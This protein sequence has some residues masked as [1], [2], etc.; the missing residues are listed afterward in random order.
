LKRLLFDLETDG[1]WEEVSHVH[2]IVTLDLDTGESQSFY[3]DRTVVHP[4]RSGSLFDGVQELR[5]A[6]ELWGHNIL[7]YDIPVLNKILKAGFN[8][9]FDSIKIRD[10]LVCSQHM[11][12]ELK[13]KDFAFRKTKPDFPGT[14]VGSHSLEA[15]GWRLDNHKD[16]FGKDADWKKFTLE[17]LTYALQD[18]ST[19]KSLIDLIVSKNYSEAALENE[20]RFQWVIWLQEQHGFRF[21]RKA[22]VSLYGELSQRRADIE[23]QLQAGFPGWYEEMKTPEYY[24]LET[25][26]QCDPLY[27]LPTKAD[28]ERKRRELGIKPSLCT[29]KPGPLKKKHTPF[30]PGSR[31]HIAKFLIEKYGWEPSQFGDDGKPT[32]DEDVLLE[33]KYPEIP[34]IS[35]YLMVEKRIGQLAEGNK[36][37]LKLE[38]NGRIHGRVN[39]NGAV[40]TRV[41]HNEPNMSQVPAVDKPFGKESRALFV[42]DEGHVL[43]GADASGIQLR[44]L[45]HYMFPWDNGEYGKIVLNGSSKLGT[46]IHTM[47]QKAAGLATRDMAKTFIYAFLLGAQ[48]GK[49]ASIAQTTRA[50]GQ[51][52][53]EN[54]LAKFPALAAL[55]SEVSQRVKSVGYLIGPDGRKLPTRSDHAAL[56]SLLQGFESAVMK[57]ATWITHEKLI[58]LG[59]VHGKD[60]AQVGYFHDELQITCR[61]D[62]GDT[63]GKTV[64]A[65]IEQAGR[66]FDSKCPLTGEYRVGAN[67]RDT[68]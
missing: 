7:K 1:L 6:S 16:T 46:D 52:L 63:V 37:W 19:N 60:F 8:P 12:L 61:P 33:L 51:K 66:E 65:A 54:F 50:K 59:L 36:A 41:T 68:H 4:S 29:I 28:A 15:W 9:F 55:K 25:H 10:T 22:A 2:C 18:L 49:V 30:N 42:A 47:N 48:A 43:V 62:L 67:W 40:S 32:V 5:K 26:H 3:D 39:T 21:D 45:S 35:E 27:Q 23:K 31:D 57:R 17:M 11:W 44:A 34:L 38:Q 53:I 13:L 58:G 20:M 14:L 64:V 24:I 56:S